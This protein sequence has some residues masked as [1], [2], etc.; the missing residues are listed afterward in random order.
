MGYLMENPPKKKRKKRGGSKQQYRGRCVWWCVWWWV[1]VV[2]KCRKGSLVA[3]RTPPPVNVQVP[4]EPLTH[5]DHS[6]P[7][8]PTRGCI[9]VVSKL[10]EQLRTFLVH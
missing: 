3:A 10:G 8:G 5:W 2:E 1:E 7:L 4:R 9:S 6:G